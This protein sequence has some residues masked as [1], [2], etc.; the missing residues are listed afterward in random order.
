MSLRCEQY[1]SL[2]ETRNLL[3]DLIVGK[4]SV[5]EAKDRA[6]YCARHYP[7]LDDHGAPMF[8]KDGFECPEIN[9]IKLF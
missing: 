9:K 7:M 2:Y 4:V 6:H 1:R 3:H 8:S 5:K